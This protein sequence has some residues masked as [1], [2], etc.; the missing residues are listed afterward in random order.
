MGRG[1]V[2]VCNVISSCCA[3]VGE[4][5]INVSQWQNATH[6]LVTRP[7]SQQRMDYMIST[8]VPDS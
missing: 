1:V 5:K 6:S 3:E 4:N 8:C 2:C 7:M